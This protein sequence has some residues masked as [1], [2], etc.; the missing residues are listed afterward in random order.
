MKPVRSSSEHN[1]KSIVGREGIVDAN[2]G[3]I[4]KQQEIK[5]FASE[6]DMQIYITEYKKLYTKVVVRIDIKN[7]NLYYIDF[8]QQ[9]MTT[10]S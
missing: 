7:N 8:P 4:Y 9:L 2:D 6:E 3:K 5:S 10:G 1:P